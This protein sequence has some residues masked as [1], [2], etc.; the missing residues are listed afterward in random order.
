MNLLPPAICSTKKDQLSRVYCLA[1]VPKVIKGAHKDT[2]R[3]ALQT[4]G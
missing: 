3:P 4:D 1:G 2:G